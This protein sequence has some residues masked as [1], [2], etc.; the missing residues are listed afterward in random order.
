[1]VEGTSGNIVRYRNPPIVEAAIS[2]EF[3]AL[4]VERLPEIKAFA[5]NLGD[6]YP[7]QTPRFQQQAQFE[8][9][10][11]V[12]YAST[13]H[14]DGVVCASQDGKRFAQFTLSSVAF[15]R[16]APYG[17]WEDFELQARPV[18]ESFRKTFRIKA[19]TL[20]LRY[21][22]RI[23]IP[24]GDVMEHYLRTYPEV[25][26]DLP[27]LIGPYFMRL[28]IPMV[29]STG[30]PTLVLQQGFVKASSSELYAILLDNDLRYNAQDAD[31][32]WRL[33]QTARQEKNRIFE[34]CIT[35]NLRERLN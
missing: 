4:P 28:E 21:I 24:T 16:L 2:V 18:W 22:N 12:R 9:G 26:H 17:S 31:D 13:Q 19:V 33:A 14:E 23:E 3:A 27:Q 8:L 7:S 30:E 35:D 5:S 15:S 20:G 34:A 29:K 32:I 1:M 6:E 25:S 10:P 11:V